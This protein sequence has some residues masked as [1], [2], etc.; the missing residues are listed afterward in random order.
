MNAHRAATAILIAAV[1]IAATYVRIVASTGDLW[2]DEIWT[3]IMVDNLAS[4]LEVFTRLHHD[5]NHYLNSIFLYWMG[6]DRALLLYRVPSLLAG[7]GTMALAVMIARQRGRIEALI[8]A[9][10]QARADKDWAAAD[11]IRDEIAELGVMIKDGADG[12]TWSRIVE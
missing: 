10:I 4:P 9:R 7:M 5:N 3:L 6:P 1:F 12:T 2:F 11:R 8:A